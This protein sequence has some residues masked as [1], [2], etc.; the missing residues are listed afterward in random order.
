MPNSR[1]TAQAAELAIPED[2]YV[3][4]AVYWERYYEEADVH[5]EWNDGYLE[6]K[7]VSDYLTSLTYY[8]FLALLQRFLAV[9]PVAV[10]IG[11]EFG[12]RL[13][14]PHKTTIRKPDLGVIRHD[15]P[16]PILPL[17]RAYG[18][19]F[20]LC[21]EALSDSNSAN[22][23][24]DWVTKKGEYANGGVPEYFILHHQQHH[25]A[26]YTLTQRGIYVPILPQEGIIYSKVLPGFGFRLADLEQRPS[27]DSLRTDPVYREFVAPSW[28]AAEQ[29]A[30]AEAQARLAAEK[31]A[32]AAEKRA[33]AAEKQTK[34]AEKQAKAAKKQ[35]KAAEKQAKAAK[36]QAEIEIQAR[37]ASEHRAQRLA[38]QLRALGIDPDTK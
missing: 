2:A 13:A 8:W 31:Q 28:Q 3:S 23:R 20:D 26:F 34:A 16:H 24:R 19:I 38:A 9:H 33:K 37:L 10:V 5:Y 22:I 15:N 1:D 17:D 4:E 30:E 32:K 14:L 21:V 35:A 29:Q 25:Q 7:P 18:G 12:F 6:E 11:L 27:I 36:K